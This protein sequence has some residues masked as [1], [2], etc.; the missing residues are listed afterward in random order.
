MRVVETVPVSVRWALSASAPRSFSTSANS[1]KPSTL[2][3]AG[4]APPT[5]STSSAALT[6]STSQ[7]AFGR[8]SASAGRLAEVENSVPSSVQC[9]DGGAAVGTALPVVCVR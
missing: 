4:G 8:H 9:P 1:G 7:T 3:A 5:G 2:S 6:S